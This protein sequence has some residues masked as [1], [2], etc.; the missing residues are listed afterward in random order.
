MG[1]TRPQGEQ[2][3]ECWDLGN[4]VELSRD[5]FPELFFWERPHLALWSSVKIEEPVPME[6]ENHLE[7][8]DGCYDNAEATFSDDEE[9][10]NSKGEGIPGIP[11]RTQNSHHAGEFLAVNTIP[12]KP[13][14]RGL[15][16][17]ENPRF[18]PA[19]RVWRS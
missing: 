19:G 3:W 6:M 7:K 11:P 1:R 12:S 4:P 9:E 17:L 2:G 16:P 18:P 5:P 14:A 13:L 10:L 15:I 8:D